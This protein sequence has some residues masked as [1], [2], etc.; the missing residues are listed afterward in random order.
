MSDIEDNTVLSVTGGAVKPKSR[1]RNKKIILLLREDLL[2]QLKNPLRTRFSIQDVIVPLEADTLPEEERQKFQWLLTFPWELPAA[3]GD[4]VPDPRL[5]FRVPGMAKLNPEKLPKHP[6]KKLKSLIDRFTELKSNLQSR[7][8][9][10]AFL[11]LSQTEAL[12]KKKKKET[13][14]M[15]MRLEYLNAEMIKVDK[16][17]FQAISYIF[18][19]AIEHL[20]GVAVLDGLM[21]GLIRIMIIDD[22]GKRTIDGLSEMNY[23]R[24]YLSYLSSRDLEKKFRDYKDEHADDEEKD[25]NLGEFIFKSPEFEKIDIV[26][27]NR[28]HFSDDEFLVPV[29]LR[30]KKIVNNQ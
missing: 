28:W 22:L 6:D 17:Y 7:D 12:L 13:L 14:E 15:K 16:A 1:L 25:I 11:K 23:S 9:N 4:Q 5:L 2:K 21:K 29:L 3:E 19:T 10:R 27:F 30:K 18:S 26:F 8:S 24:K 20:T